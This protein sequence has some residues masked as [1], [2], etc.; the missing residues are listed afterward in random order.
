M[1]ESN[2]LRFL[3]RAVADGALFDKLWSEAIDRLRRRRDSA[4]RSAAR[5]AMAGGGAEL[6]TYSEECILA[7]THGD[8]AAFP[9]R[10]DAAAPLVTFADRLETP[11][12]E[13]LARHCEVVLV[14][15]GSELGAAD[16][17]GVDRQ[18]K[19][20]VKAHGKL[21]LP[22][23]PRSCFLPCWELPVPNPLLVPVLMAR[24]EVQEEPEAPSSQPFSSVRTF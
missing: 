23:G 19:G 13:V 3:A 16:S 4:L 22:G 17:E 12:A 1:L 7:L 6:G 20:Q 21:R 14:R 2:Y 5:L 24:P 18:G 8:V 10:N 15:G 9:G 11:S